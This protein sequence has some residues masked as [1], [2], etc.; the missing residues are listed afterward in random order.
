MYII[1]TSIHT[2]CY[3]TWNWTQL[4]PV[5]I[6]HPWDVSTTWLKSTCG[7]FNWHDLERHT[8]VYIRSHSWQCTSEQKPS[9]EVNEI[10]RRAQRSPRTQ[11]PPS[12]LNGRSFEP[13]RLFLEL[14]ALP[15]N[16]KPADTGE[17]DV[18]MKPCWSASWMYSMALVSAT[19]RGYMR[20]RGGSEPASRSVAQSQGRWGGRQVAQVLNNIS[21]RSW[22]TSGMLGWRATTGLSTDVEPQGKGKLVPGIRV[23]SLWLSS[24]TMR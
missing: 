10:V 19:D 17:V 22:Y 20:L 8:P 21:R 7:K 15:M 2:F 24:S 14:A 3:E 4:Q 18:P 6:D 13:P 11:L 23:P 12:F 5:S 16:Q 9:H 1:Y